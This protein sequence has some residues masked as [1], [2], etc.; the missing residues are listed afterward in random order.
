[1]KILLLCYGGMSTNLLVS[2]IM[3][4]A[5]K[6]NFNCEVRA[7]AASLVEEIASQYDVILIA[8]QIRH[9]LATIRETTTT[10]NK[11]VALIPPDIYG[12]IQGDK[13]LAFAQQLLKS[14]ETSEV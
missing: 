8:P 2:S 14:N 13:A 11:P 6:Q 1:M 4:A 10:Y 7:S 5:K 3:Q 9:K 12:Q